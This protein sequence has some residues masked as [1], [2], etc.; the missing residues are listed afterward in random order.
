MKKLFVFAL[1]VILL[2]A[3]G[4][5]DT[6]DSLVKQAMREAEKTIP[7]EE[8]PHLGTLPVLW[9]QRDEARTQ[10]DKMISE[11]K[12]K[13]D[14]KF[15]KGGS[16]EDRIRNSMI[17]E[18]LEKESKAELERIFKEKIT[19]E[20]IRLEGQSIPVDF[21]KSAFSDAKVT[22]QLSK[23]TSMNAP[24]IFNA[25][26]TLAAPLLSKKSW[27]SWVRVEWESKDKGNETIESYLSGSEGI[28]NAEKYKEGDH[29]T[30]E[31][32]PNVRYANIEKAKEFGKLY[33]SKKE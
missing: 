13:A 8:T 19:A 5:G 29:F 25:D 22:I 33:F 23:D 1:T 3:C 27:W 31:I 28:N 12:E 2:A 10:V 11:R 6:P 18:D 32:R 15:K 21:D 20:A 9:A 17:I 14:E 24:V 26:L 16:M 30:F 4:G 7:S